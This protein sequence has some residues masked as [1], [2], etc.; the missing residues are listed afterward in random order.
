MTFLSQIYYDPP[1]KMAASRRSSVMA[2]ITHS[3]SV[4]HYEG[5]G[6]GSM[7]SAAL[8]I[9]MAVLAI[10]IAVPAAIATMLGAS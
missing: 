6:H 5:E 3:H 9:G 10:A 4:P 8:Y 1:H 2:H 7:K